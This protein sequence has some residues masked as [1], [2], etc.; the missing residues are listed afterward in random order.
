MRSSVNVKITPFHIILFLFFNNLQTTREARRHAGNDYF[1]SVRIVRSNFR[2]CAHFFKPHFFKTF[3]FSGSRDGQNVSHFSV[4][5]DVRLCLICCNCTDLL[6][7]ICS[8]H[9]APYFQADFDG[10]TEMI[11]ALHGSTLGWRTPQGKD[12]NFENFYNKHR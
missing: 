7:N 9:C 6:Q 2:I 11:A 8:L 5:G 3:F 4:D 1:S 10:V 12:T